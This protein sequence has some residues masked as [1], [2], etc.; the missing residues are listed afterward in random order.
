MARG[1]CWTRT[2]PPPTPDGA[3]GLTLGASG[4]HLT[5]CMPGMRASSAGG[6]GCR[7]TVVCSHLRALHP[8][9]LLVHWALLGPLRNGFVPFEHS[10]LPLRQSF[11]D[12]V[13][14]SGIYKGCRASGLAFCAV[15]DALCDA[16]MTLTSDGRSAFAA[17]WILLH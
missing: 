9:L 17:P 8:G 16:R 14:R 13:L 6:C 4:P 15:C 3:S 1:F 7:W 12:C 5:Y 11:F 10:A 2:S